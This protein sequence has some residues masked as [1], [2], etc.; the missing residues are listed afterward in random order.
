[1][2]PEPSVTEA[3]ESIERSLASIESGEPSLHA[4]TC[5]DGDR[6]RAAAIHQS[7]GPLAGLT[8]GIKDIFDT[9]DL[10]TAYGS[11]IYAEYQP[12]ADASA[13]A[14]LRAAGALIMGKT[15][16]A[17]LAWSTPGPTRNPHR[18]THTPGG[19]SSGS[20]AAVAAGMVDLALGTQTA[21]SVIRPAS[22]CGIYGFK[23]TF[24]LIPTAGLKPGAP[25]LDTVGIMSIDLEYLDRARLAVTRR[26]NAFDERSLTFGLLRTEMWQEA[27][28]DCR[29]VI[30]R[31]ATE[32]NAREVELPHEL[33]GLADDC[34]IIQAYEGARSLAWERENHNELLSPGLRS[35]LAWG[36]S[37][38]QSSYDDVR[39]R[40]D[41]SRSPARMDALFSTFDVLITPAVIGEA[42]EGLDSTGD[43]KFCR[44]WTALGLPALSVPG[45]FGA[46]GLPI[47]VQLI[48]RPFEDDKLIFAARHLRDLSS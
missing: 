26:K 42:P 31:A 44:L 41:A 47:G 4:W 35:R 46:T 16:T 33:V 22:F 14:I 13:V 5:I 30:E 36:D 3:L 29:D 1:M 40:V 23:P 6:A 28:P 24:G 20:A 45:S 18:T 48:A 43:P 34:Q 7:S 39:R 32:L 37:L 8:L 21:G 15:V 10:P 9:A 38:P 12:R 25:S 27:D 2:Q 11:A 17:E 19:S